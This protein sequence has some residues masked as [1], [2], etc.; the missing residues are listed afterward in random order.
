[1]K[2]PAGAALNTRTC[3]S[4]LNHARQEGKLTS[5]CDVVSYLLATYA[6]VAIIA[7]AGMNIKNSRQIACQSAVEYVQVLWTRSLRFGSV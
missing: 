1:M 6:T 3:L 7:K 4:S 5:Y 2:K